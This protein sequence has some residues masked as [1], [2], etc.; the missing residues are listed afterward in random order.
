M[1]SESTAEEF[2]HYPDG[3]DWLSELPLH[4]SLQA[5]E[6]EESMSRHHIGL[7]KVAGKM[8]VLLPAR[9]VSSVPCTGNKKMSGEV[10]VEQVGGKY[11]YLKGS[12]CMIP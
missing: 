2:Q 3:A 10:L 11:I 6:T 4:A 8:P 1:L 9:T 7:A 12:R 5:T